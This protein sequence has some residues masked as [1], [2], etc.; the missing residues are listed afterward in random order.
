MTSVAKKI[1]HFKAQ[2]GVAAAFVVLA[3][4]GGIAI[5]NSASGS[6]D[7]LYRS[8]IASCHRANLLRMESNR[9]I[10]SHEADTSVLRAFLSAAQEAREQNYIASKLKSDNEAAEEYG[11]LIRVLD[12]RVVFKPIG[13][14]HCEEA[15]KK[16]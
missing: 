5:E 1:G 7:S 2:Y 10:S 11:H 4:I 13:L 16:P 12:K 3:L 6:A 14:V 15:V 9:R 8:Q